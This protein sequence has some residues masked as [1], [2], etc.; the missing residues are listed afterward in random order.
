M[1]L[2]WFFLGG[3][4]L[5]TQPIAQHAV[6]DKSAKERA[7]LATL[8]QT[9]S[10]YTM[11]K[12]SGA[13]HDVVFIAHPAQHEQRVPLLAITLGLVEVDSA[14]VLRTHREPQC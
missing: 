11:H 8:M 9:H 14:L 5:W 12:H 10:G 2:A 4:I 1:V 6:P 7:D 13:H 3:S